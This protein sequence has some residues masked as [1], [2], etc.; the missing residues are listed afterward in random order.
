MVVSNILSATKKIISLNLMSAYIK[1]FKNGGKN[2]KMWKKKI[3]IENDSELIKY[4]KDWNKVKD[5][6]YKISSHVCWWWKLH[7]ILK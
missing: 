6:E 3:M 2:M 7:K 4:N 1:Y 5:L